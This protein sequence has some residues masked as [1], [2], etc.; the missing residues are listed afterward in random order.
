MPPH[1]ISSSDAEMHKECICPGQMYMIF[2]T[3]TSPGFN[4]FLL[5]AFLSWRFLCIFSNLQQLLNGYLSLS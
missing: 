4:Y 2:S 5:M 3:D 1:P